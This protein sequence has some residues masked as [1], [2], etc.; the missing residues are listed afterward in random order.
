MK[1][2][3][4]IFLFTISTCV[5][6]SSIEKNSQKL[7]G[8]WTFVQFEE[9]KKEGVVITVTITKFVENVSFKFNSDSTLEVIYSESKREKYFWKTTNRD[10]I[11]ITFADSNNYN[12]RILGLFEIHFLDKISQL[13]LQRENEPHNDI[14]LK[15]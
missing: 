10:L 13:Y 15:K 7:I 5:G 14:M 9:A 8:N 4:I 11:E 12:S 1:T 3:A 6:Q 2:L